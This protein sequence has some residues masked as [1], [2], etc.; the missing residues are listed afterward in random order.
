[1]KNIVLCSLLLLVFACCLQGSESSIQAAFIEDVI[2]AEAWGM[3]GAYRTAVTGAGSLVFNPAGLA[4]MKGNR[5]FSVEQAELM[6]FFSCSFMGYAHRLGERSVLGTG[7]LYSGD[8]VLSEF[9]GYLSLGL[10]GALPGN[11]LAGGVIPEKLLFFGITGKFF[12]ASFGNN[13]A[14][15]DL[16]PELLANRVSG[17]ASGFGID[18]GLKIKPTSKDNFS[19]VFKNPVNYIRWKSEN[20]AGT[21][22]GSYSENLPVN[23]TV[24]YLRKEEKFRAAIDLQKSLF[25]DEEDNLHLGV[26][27]FLSK[28]FTLRGGYAQELVTADSKRLTFGAGFMAGIAGLTNIRFDLA[29][30][31]YLEWE[32]Y[33]SLFLSVSL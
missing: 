4:D 16:H 27:Y 20:S 31:L 32:R 10:D 13:S 18:L 26:E 25:Y 12:Y 19:L 14:D 24:G 17:S 21:A 9:T 2:G 5:S 3:G 7:L 22:L 33:N 6:E 1:M 30:L 8:D 11:L 29:Y 15:S 23:W 28:E